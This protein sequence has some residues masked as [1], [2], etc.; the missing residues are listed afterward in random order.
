LLFSIY[1][2]AKAATVNFVQAISQEWEPFDVKVNSINPRT[3]KARE[4]K[5]FGNEPEATLLDPDVVAMRS[6]PNF[7]SGYTGQVIDVRLEKKADS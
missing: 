1:S 4:Q 5:N 6:I 2:S 3:N 7:Y